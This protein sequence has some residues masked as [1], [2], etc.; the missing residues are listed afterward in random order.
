[1]LW[2]LLRMVLEGVFSNKDA[3]LWQGSLLSSIRPTSAVLCCIIIVFLRCH[4]YVLL[5]PINHFA[6]SSLMYA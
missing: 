4:M 5:T 3:V 2:C 6:L 1:M